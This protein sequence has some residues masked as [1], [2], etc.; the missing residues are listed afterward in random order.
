MEARRSSNS[1]NQQNQTTRCHNAVHS[2]LDARRNH[3]IRKRMPAIRFCEC[4]VL[5][6]KYHVQHPYLGACHPQRVTAD[7]KTLDGK[8]RQQAYLAFPLARQLLSIVNWLRT[9]QPRNRGSIPCTAGHISKAS[10]P[11]LGPTYPPTPRRSGAFY[12]GVKRAR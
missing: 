4:M 9:G 1:V 2:D 11:E 6:S 12:Q 3:T 10:R 8:N 5:T 7:V